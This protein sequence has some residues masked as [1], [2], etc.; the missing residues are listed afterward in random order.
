MDRKINTP[1]LCY[2]Y[3]LDGNVFNKNIEID[4]LKDKYSQY[5]FGRLKG[6]P[7]KSEK[8]YLE[9]IY[10]RSYVIQF[11]A[12]KIIFPLAEIKF[13]ELL[14]VFS[15]AYKYYC[16]VKKNQYENNQKQTSII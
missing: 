15:E 8:I 2:W 4:M 1:K 7:R 11:I 3:E 14:G 9:V 12:K 13:S 5:L 16:R 6:Q 10:D